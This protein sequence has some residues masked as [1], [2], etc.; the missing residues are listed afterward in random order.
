MAYE[1][2]IAESLS[3]RGHNDEM[4]SAYSA[5]PTGPGPFPGVVLIHH[6]PGW[7]EFYR[8]MT[9][10]FA[11]H[12]YAAISH[13]LYHRAMRRTLPPKRG[14]RAASPTIR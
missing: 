1:G 12:G 10:K 5:R 6:L 2:M 14:R 9:R 13:N 11:H 8:E 7:G 4:I 3:I